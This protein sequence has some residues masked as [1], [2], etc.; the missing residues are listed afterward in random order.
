MSLD[1]VIIKQ[2]NQTQS[3]LT[4]LSDTEMKQILDAT[5]DTIKSVNDIVVET[6][7]PRTSAYR[8]INWMLEQGLL[9]VMK[10]VITDDGKKMSLFQSALKSIKITYENTQIIV[11]AEKNIDVMGRVAHKFFSLN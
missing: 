7:I 11:E 8:K 6:R 3:I 5:T 1:T 2:D 9:G 10:I 4:M